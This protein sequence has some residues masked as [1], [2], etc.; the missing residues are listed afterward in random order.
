MLSDAVL[1]EDADFTLDAPIK[2]WY[3]VAVVASPMIK[4]AVGKK[5]QEAEDFLH[6][7]FFNKGVLDPETFGIDVSITE[8]ENGVY[9]GIQVTEF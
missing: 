9:V 5:L 4:K 7:A 3:K 6:A 2:A 8:N 1:T